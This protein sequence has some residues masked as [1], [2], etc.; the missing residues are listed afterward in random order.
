MIKETLHFT[1]LHHYLPLFTNL[2]I[3][4]W[5][6]KYDKL[7]RMKQRSTRTCSQNTIIH[8]LKED[9]RLGIK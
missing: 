3:R 2:A 5:A 7:K 8:Y 4:Q 6:S 9:L 1:K